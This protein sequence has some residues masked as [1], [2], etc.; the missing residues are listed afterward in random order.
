MWDPIGWVI[1]VGR[2]IHYYIVYY[3]KLGPEGKTDVLMRVTALFGVLWLVLF[4]M[5]YYGR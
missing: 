5:L 2:A 4:M 3:N 1:G